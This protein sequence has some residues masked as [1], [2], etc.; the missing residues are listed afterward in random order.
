MRVAYP[1]R[2]LMFGAARSLLAEYPQNLI[3][4]LDVESN[5]KIISLQAIDK[6]LRH[7]VSLNNVARVDSEFVER[8]GMYHIS[9]VTADSPINQ[10]E[11]ESQEGPELRHDIIHG[12]KSTIR[13][14]SERPG[15]LDTLVYSE[16]PDTSPL[17]DDEVEVDVQ[18]AGMNPKDLVNAMGFVP[19]NEHQFGLECTGIV[20]EIGKNVNTVKPGDKV[21]MV[22]RDRG[23]FANRVRN[24]WLA[25]YALPDWISL[26]E[27]TTLG[28]AVHTAVYGLV[29]LADVQKGQSVLV[30]SASGGVGLA[31]IDL[32]KYL[33]AE[34]Y[35]TVGTDAKRDFLAENY[36]IPRARMFSSRSTTFAAELLRV[37]NGRGVDVCLN[38]LTGDMLHESWRC[39][40][41]NG[42]LIEIG[43]KDM[44]ERVH[45]SMELFGRNCSYCALDLSRKS[46]TDEVTRKIGLQIMDLVSQGHLKPL[47]ISAVFPFEETVEAFR[48]MQRGKHIGKVVISFEKS[49]TVKLPFPASHP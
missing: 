39:I 34:I 28:I 16:L 6:A 18:A 38:S 24:R 12:H 49:N 48:Y 4:Y 5:A 31:A 45:L 2:G 17:E 32:C 11:K 47:H 43:K 23:C 1:E 36:D 9:R 46:I 44:L 26:E 33:G 3:L 27:G 30:H 29:T 35:V 19:A 22:G 41:E 42:S 14:I 21:L 7:L 20:T 8:D 13:L 10:A 25:V 15:T 40:A 37:T